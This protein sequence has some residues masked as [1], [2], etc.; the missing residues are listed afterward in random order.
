MS[1][2]VGE[3]LTKLTTDCLTQ[4]EKKQ[5][6]Y[7][8]NSTERG[9]SKALLG[10]RGVGEVNIGGKGH[11][12]AGL[13]ATIKATLARP[14]G[15]NVV[16]TEDQGSPFSTHRMNRTG[17][18]PSLGYGSKAR[19]PYPTISG[20]I[21]YDFSRLTDKKRYLVDEKTELAAHLGGLD[22]KAA[23]D[24]AVFKPGQHG[25]ANRP[26]PTIQVGPITRNRLRKRG[27]T[28]DM[29]EQWKIEESDSDPDELEEDEDKSLG[30]EDMVRIKVKKT[31]PEDAGFDIMDVNVIPVILTSREGTVE[32]GWKV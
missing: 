17:M 12:E 21:E 18:I 30:M 9:S 14:P 7:M 2:L 11:I 25:V 20:T 32:M 10:I 22:D 8:I 5:L 28:L 31:Y 4:K 1:S 23:K 6:P 15:T 24:A 16:E 3:Q 29:P 26:I 19:L 27:G 13:A